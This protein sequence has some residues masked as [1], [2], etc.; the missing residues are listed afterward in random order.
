LRLQREDIKIGLIGHFLAALVFLIF[1]EPIVSALSRVI[2][3][4]PPFLFRSYLD[5]LYAETSTGVP[6]YAFLLCSLVMITPI[7]AG[8]GYS[9]ARISFRTHPDHPVT[10]SRLVNAIGI[11]MWAILMVSATIW[12]ADSYARLQI[13]TSFH[14]YVTILT[15]QITEADRVGLLAEFASMRGKDDYFALMSRIK[16]TAV[17]L[18]QTLPPNKLYPLFSNIP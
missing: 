8:V 17:A 10:R 18:H 14:Q 2:L 13:Y 12:V 11:G 16:A 1:L 4:L 5:R 15:P 9:V 3:A 7:A 6:D